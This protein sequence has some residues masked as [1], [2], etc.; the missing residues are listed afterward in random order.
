MGEERYGSFAMTSD[1]LERSSP[2]TDVVMLAS[3]RRDGSP[4]VVPVGF[5][6]DGESFYVTIA[7][8]HAG[9]SPTPARP[10]G[11]VGRRAAIPRSPPSSSWSRAS[12]RRSPIPTTRSAGASCSASRRRCSPAWG[13]T[14][15]ATSRTGS[16]WAASRSAS[17]STSLATLRRHEGEGGA[18]LGRHT[19]ADRHGASAA[20]ATRRPRTSRVRR[21]A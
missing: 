15:S 16:R 14:A 3:L 9:V 12:P 4:F 21:A 11:L 10:P 8:D 13:S 19:P 6:W 5:D 2:S 17:G 18:V 1:E 20:D 7:L